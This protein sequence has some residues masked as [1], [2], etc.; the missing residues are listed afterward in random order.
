MRKIYLL[1]VSLMTMAYLFPQISRAAEAQY[2]LKIVSGAVTVTPARMNLAKPTREDIKGSFS[3]KLNKNQITFYDFAMVTK[4]GN[5]FE[6]PALPGEL[7]D[8]LISGIPK[9]KKFDQGYEGVFDG[10]SMSITGAIDN[11]PFD[12]PLVEYRFRAIVI[13]ASVTQYPKGYFTMR[14][15]YRKCA[16]PLCGG[17]FVKLA[18]RQLTRCS[19]RVYRSECYVA[20]AVWNNT[21]AP[22]SNNLEDLLVYGGI[23]GKKY[24]NFGQ[25]GEFVI[26]S[27]YQGEVKQKVKNVLF[28]GL[29]NNGIQCIT[30]PCFSM[31]EYILNGT[32][33]I[34]ASG[35]NWAQTNISEDRLAAAND[36]LANDGL[37][38]MA[39][40]N[41]PEKGMAGQGLTFNVRQVY[42][43]LAKCAEG[44]QEKNGQCVS[45][46]GCVAPQ[47][48][49]KTYG[50]AAYR[51][52]MTGE[53]KSSLSTAC[54]STCELPGIYNQGICRVYAP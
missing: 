26:D 8:G 43:P 32:T 11:R 31:K 35:I 9:I 23:I 20:K 17:V 12:G 5:P 27:V 10:E 30:T 51:D 54:V 39:G 28:I 22:Q 6:L 49:Q 53:I 25:L 15:D 18:N 36:V 42:L 14:Q 52:P 13:K 3:I 16:S 33:T 45:P 44:Y 34:P 29:K 4:S 46:F 7:K 24:A 40:K 50:G 1:L 38:L 47:I 19:D 2:K 41:Q 48:E 37:L 21:S